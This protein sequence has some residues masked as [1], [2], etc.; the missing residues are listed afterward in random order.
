MPT[1]EKQKPSVQEVQSAALYRATG[2][3]RVG[4]RL[5]VGP[6]LNTCPYSALTSA[7]IMWKGFCWVTLYWGVSF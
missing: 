7:S 4:C 6:L 2:E 1:P 3:E 5:S